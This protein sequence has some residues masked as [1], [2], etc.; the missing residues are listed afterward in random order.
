MIA[1]MLAFAIEILEAK[2]L[3]LP[4]RNGHDLGLT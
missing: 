1:I 4:Y 3:S 2:R